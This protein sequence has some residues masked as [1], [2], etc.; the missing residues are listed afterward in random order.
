MRLHIPAS[1][2]L[3]LS[4][5][6]VLSGKS[7][8]VCQTTET[9]LTYE[10]WVELDEQKNILF[11]KE[12]IHW[13]NPTQDEVR[14]MWF[15]LYYNAFKNENSAMIQ[16]SRRKGNGI[17]A[18]DVQEEQLGWIEVTR[19][20]L[21][22]GTNLSP[23]MAFGHPDGPLY[24][25]DQ[26]VMK[27]DLPKPVLP[28]NEVQIHL[29]FQAKIPSAL[30]RS[31]HYKNSYF[32][33]QWFPKPGV[34]EEGKGWN[35]HAYHLTSEF[36]ADF[37]DFIVHITVP[38]RYVLG[39]SGKQIK[40]EASGNNK[41]VTYTFQQKKIHDF[42]W[43]ASPR[44]IKIERDFTADKE[45]N[46][47]DYKKTAQKLDLPV[48]EVK[49]PDIEMIL[50]LL[51]EHRGQADR[52][53]KALKAAIKYYGLW[54]GPYPYETITMVDPPFRTGSE[55]MEYP[56]LFTAGTNVLLCRDVLSPESV[57]IHEFG[58]GYW[59]GLSANNEF[60][61][62]WL[63]E[64][65][66][67]YST[68]N[69]LAAAYGPGEYSLIFSGIPLELFFKLPE[70]FA[71]EL[72]RVYA[73]GIVK[74]DPVVTFSWKFI[75]GLSYEYNVYQRASTLL[76]T[77]ERLVGEDTMLKV[78]RTFQMRFRYRHPQTKD[79]I[80]VINEVSRRD[81]SWFFEEFFFKTLDF[82]YCVSSLR[83][84]EKNL[85]HLGF[86]DNNRKIEGRANKS[87]E[88]N[89]KK[90][91]GR[92][93]NKTFVT[94]VVVQRLGEAELSGDAEVKL[95]VVFKDGSRQEGSWD[96]RE[97]WKL[98]VFESLSPAEFARIDPDNVWL[99]DSC[100]TNNSLR[101][102]PSRKGIWSLAAKLFFWIQNGLHVLS[103]LS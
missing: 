44:F 96:G 24:L 32:I 35:C 43:T 102:K 79:F 51:P 100:I 89:T 6:F 59:Y 17:F 3:L 21:A 20:Q 28:G 70:Y 55:A 74:I 2:I 42:A 49:L 15:H 66:N 52:H 16:E 25:K 84:F 33:A 57:I 5:M 12:D 67:T 23:E 62:A 69:V 37:A 61:E 64:G 86:I 90:K 78:L 91:K 36:F 60:E 19:L 54:Y 30:M 63:D 93:Q 65:I 94:E 98:F 8:L 82:D 77:L 103:G 13:I 39:A 81:L 22:D 7:Y 56:T 87:V 88:K 40:A 68:G 34:Y 26:T 47:D 76:H 45:I 58:H 50:L 75:N 46:P 73:L 80:D 72:D 14:D 1:F 41:T 101:L 99:I 10:I 18:L 4:M 9:H 48:G 11:G 71:Y 29:E 85:H 53:F 97:R 38:E 92:E 95:V 31:G 83:S 27:V